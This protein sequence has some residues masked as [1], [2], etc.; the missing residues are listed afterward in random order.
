MRSNF[1]KFSAHVAYGRISVL[2]WQRF[3]MLYSSSFVD[4]MF[5]IMDS[6][7]ASRYRSS[8]AAVYVLTPLLRWYWLVL[9]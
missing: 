5:L 1:T 6:M 2:F 3:N 8:I 9:S 4:V 7:A